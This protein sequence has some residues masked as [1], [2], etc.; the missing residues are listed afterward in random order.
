MVGFCF[1]WSA[2][3]IFLESVGI[4]LAYNSISSAYVHLNPKYVH[5]PVYKNQ[6]D[7]PKNA[8]QSP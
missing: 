4:S 7:W 8:Y 2:G 1:G 6:Q 5:I 3:V